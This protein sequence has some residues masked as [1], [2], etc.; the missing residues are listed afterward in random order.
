MRANENVLRVTS[1]WNMCMN[2]HWQVCAI[3]GRLHGQENGKMHFSIAPKDLDVGIFDSPESCIGGCDGG[4]A[5]SDVYFAEICVLSHICKNRA[6][7]FLADVGT[8]FECDFDE[9]RF[10]ELRTLLGSSERA[11]D[12]DW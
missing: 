4:Y 3:Q 8:I 6:E 7:L 12:D 2:L 9:Q 1:G 10:L 11:D 5:I